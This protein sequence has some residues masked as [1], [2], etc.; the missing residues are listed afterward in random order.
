MRSVAELNSVLS[1]FVVGVFCI[2]AAL[3]LLSPAGYGYLLME[4][5][6]PEWL[7]FLLLV[8]AGWFWARGAWVRI[9]SRQWVGAFF[10]IGMALFSLFVAGEEIAWGQRLLVFQPPDYFV[11]HNVQRE[12]T[13]HNLLIPWLQPRKLSV[14]FMMAYG[15]FLPLLA[16][17][18]SP[19]ARLLRTLAIPVPTW[20]ASLGFILAAWLMTLP[21]TATDD[22]VGELLFAIAM[23]GSGFPAAGL[24][25]KDGGRFFSQGFILLALA[26]CILS[27]ISFMDEEQRTHLVKVGP[28]QAGQ[29]FEGRGKLGEAASE[30]E[31]LARYWRTDWDLWIKVMTFYKRGGNSRKAF[32]LASWFLRVHRR[33][34]RAYQ[35]LIDIGH[36]WGIHDDVEA[37]IQEVLAEEP[38]SEYALRALHYLS[39]KRAEYM[40]ELSPS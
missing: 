34:W 33:E 2:F 6:P 31:K 18:W 23:V 32:E 24:S 36:C 3:L 5:T 15:V 29:A 35:L 20:G 38:E 7:G 22:E 12:L 39:G 40:G 4:D 19:F 10:V 21:V 17:L 25:G 26:A 11:H 1:L 27:T 8:A 28:L 16:R 14:L 30:Y 37:Q 9:S 13:L